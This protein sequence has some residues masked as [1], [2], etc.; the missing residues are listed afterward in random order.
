MRVAFWASLLWLLLLQWLPLMFS[1]LSYVAANGSGARYV[2]TPEQRASANASAWWLLGWWLVPT[3]IAAGYITFHI[4]QGHLWRKRDDPILTEYVKLPWYWRWFYWVLTP[5]VTLYALIS[6]CRIII[7]F[8]L[9]EGTIPY[10][11]GAV[12]SLIAV[13]GFYL[14]FFRSHQHARKRMIT[15]DHLER[16]RKEEDFSRIAKTI[17]DNRP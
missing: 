9:F 5:L 7:A 12:F 1:I 16:L 15:V 6:V 13:L 4:V 3:F 14:I 8:M 17:K 10:L 11:S 2:M